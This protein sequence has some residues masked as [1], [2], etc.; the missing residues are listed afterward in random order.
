MPKKAQSYRP[1]H[2]KTMAQRRREHDE[3]RGSERQ[4]YGSTKWR[5]FRAWFLSLHPLCATPS[6]NKPATDVHHARRRR[7]HPEDT[8]NQ[9]ACVA[10][11]HACHSRVTAKED[12][13]F[14]HAKRET[15]GTIGQDG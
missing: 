12:G 6:C 13:A 11:C 9:D 3:R 10:Y 5:K 4:F 1:P 15:D 7:D 14:G 8:F 2:A